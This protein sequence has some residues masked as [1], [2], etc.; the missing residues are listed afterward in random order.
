MVIDSEPDYAMAIY[1][2]HLR[3]RGGPG[4]VVQTYA[5]RWL[6]ERYGL[7]GPEAR[8]VRDRANRFLKDEGYIERINER[9]SFVRIL[10]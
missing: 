6:M 10:K 2:E 3:S 9:S 7:E 1:Q 5:H 4:E 8:T